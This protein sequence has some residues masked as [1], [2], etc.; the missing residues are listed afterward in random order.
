MN[1]IGH[2]EVLMK[3]CTGNANGTAENRGSY[4]SVERKRTEL[5]KGVSNGHPVPVAAPTAL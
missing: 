2:K 4:K 1:V 3:T 5:P